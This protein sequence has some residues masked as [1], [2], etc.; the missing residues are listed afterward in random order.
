MFADPKHPYTRDL[1]AAEPKPDFL[2]EVT[3]NFAAWDAD[4]S[5]EISVAEA[6]HRLG[7]STGVV[8]YWIESAQLDARRGPGNRLCITW[9][10]TVEAACQRRLAASPPPATSTP[11]PDAAN[12]AHGDRPHRKCQCPRPS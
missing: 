5:G 8:Y 10:P 6:A 4:Q 2:A 1:L 7:C 9:T 12:P 3:A 11:Q